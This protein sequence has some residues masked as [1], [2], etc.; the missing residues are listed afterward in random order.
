MMAMDGCEP[1]AYSLDIMGRA[2]RKG[3]MKG[4]PRA[5]KVLETV[6]GGALAEIMICLETELIAVCNRTY[7]RRVKVMLLKNLWTR[8][9]LC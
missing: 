5:T 7:S 3:W 1:N 2:M 4:F 9:C 8:F 6:M